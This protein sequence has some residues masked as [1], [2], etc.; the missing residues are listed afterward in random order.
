M[1]NYKINIISNIDVIICDRDMSCLS[2]TVI[3]MVHKLQ[4]LQLETD[5]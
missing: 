4:T 3:I 1:Y 2:D 5:C